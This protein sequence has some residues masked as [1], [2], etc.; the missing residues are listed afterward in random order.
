MQF[1]LILGVFFLTIIAIIGGYLAW[2]TWLDPNRARTQYVVCAAC[3]K[4]ECWRGINMC[5]QN[6]RGRAEGK[7][8]AMPRGLF[9]RLWGAAKTRTEAEMQAQANQSDQEWLDK[10]W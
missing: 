4:E 7:I 5:S 2:R 1:E 8:I 6:S 9:A 3:G 10:Q